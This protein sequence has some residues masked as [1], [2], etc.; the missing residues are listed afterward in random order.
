M[1]ESRIFALHQLTHT[2]THPPSPPFGHTHNNHPYFG[3]PPILWRP[4]RERMKDSYSTVTRVPPGW[5]VITHWHN[6]LV[7]YPPR[8]ISP[9][10]SVRYQNKYFQLL[11]SRGHCCTACLTLAVFF[12]NRKGY[13]KRCVASQVKGPH[14]VHGLARSTPAPI[15]WAAASLSARAVRHALAACPMLTALY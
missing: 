4:A 13:W 3:D 14:S 6:S 5:Y 9:L 11:L 2:H 15:H 8:P 7:N 1:R 12:I 10:Q